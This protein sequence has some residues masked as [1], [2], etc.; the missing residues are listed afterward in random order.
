[1]FIIEKFN[2]LESTNKYAF[3]LVSENKSGESIDHKVI[4][5]YNQT[6]GVGKQG[7]SWYSYKGNLAATLIIPYRD[8]LNHKNF[9]IISL[10]SS[11]SVLK[12][13]KDY[14]PEPEKLSIKW[15]N[16]VLYDNKKISGILIDIATS[17]DNKKYFIIGCGV[18]LKKAPKIDKYPVECLFNILSKEINVDEYLD[19][20]LFYF[21]YYIVNI[22]EEEIEKEWLSYAYNLNVPITIKTIQNSNI[23]GIFAGITKE[24]YINI[25]VGNEIKTI[26]SG[27]IKF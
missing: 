16:D 26:I 5:A 8:T 23:T 24:G 10:L 9:G 11:L 14:I 4:L 20:I 25:K 27:E 18:N 17:I 13:L 12:S 15:P 22:N 21:K 19:R 2:E 6:A 1:M 7:V 3:Q